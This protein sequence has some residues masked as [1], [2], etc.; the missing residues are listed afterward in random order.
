VAK[1]RR[2]ILRTLAR[3]LV[4]IVILHAAWSSALAAEPWSSARVHTLLAEGTPY[5]TPAYLLGEPASVVVL[6]T[7]GVH[8]DEPAGLLAAR[9]LLDHGAGFA[10]LRL[11]VV[12]VANRPAVERGTRTAAGHGDLNRAFPGGL[13]GAPIERLAHDILALIEELGVNFVID[14]HESRRSIFDDAARF[15]DT[16]IV[17]PHHDAVLAAS[18]LQTRLRV[19]RPEV[20]IAVEGPAAAGSLVDAAGRMGVPGIIV[21]SDASQDLESRV[22][23]HHTVLDGLLRGLAGPP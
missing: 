22:A 7:G 8:G 17:N 13:G 12:P 6:V 16:M 5:A 3:T 10:G 15:G 23:Y 11:V 21:E 1:V 2:A 20:R 14:L 18:M 9:R 4:A 19:E